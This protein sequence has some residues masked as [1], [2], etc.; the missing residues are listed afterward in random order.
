M[1]N[2]LNVS[3][4]AS[5]P[6]E[7]KMLYKRV[8]PLYTR[9]YGKE[10]GPVALR[11]AKTVA[12]EV[13]RYSASC[14]DPEWAGKCVALASVHP[15]GLDAADAL[16]ERFP[17][18]DYAWLLMAFNRFNILR[19][20]D[21]APPDLKDPGIYRALVSPYI[22]ESNLILLPPEAFV[23]VVDMSQPQFYKGFQA[24]KL[25]EV[26]SHGSLDEIN[27]N[28]AVSMLEYWRPAAIQLLL[29]GCYDRQ[30]DIAAHILYP[31]LF[32]N[33][34][35]LFQSLEGEIN[36]VEE[37]FRE[38]IT[39]II[40]LM[41]RKKIPLAKQT[42][43]ETGE[44]VDFNIRLKTPGSTTIKL[45]SKKEIDPESWSFDPNYVLEQIHDFIAATV[46]ADKVH[47]AEALF[48][49]ICSRD[50]GFIVDKEP[51][52][53]GSQGRQGSLPDYK[54][55]GHIDY[56]AS[57][58]G[59]ARL[60]RTELH[61]KSY[62]AYLD[63]YQCPRTGRGARDS[64]LIADAWG[65]HNYGIVQ[66]LGNFRPEPPNVNRKRNGNG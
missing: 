2:G 60:R 56:E 45:V 5:N 59:A 38:Y 61:V 30:S 6:H 35:N 14:K 20:Q 48:H 58:F 7:R 33:V 46:A 3:A 13:A 28:L 43:R 32:N 25:H 41:A 44:H 23:R 49:L 36:H 50:G 24:Q 27:R 26:T 57:A 65:D 22:S 15:L 18:S 47:D 8:S 53:R 66:A 10:D 39:T 37:K 64:Q 31:Q 62:Q 12:E 55:V 63:Y 51:L 16:M 21:E 34:K 17:K 54:G 52:F 4:L 40:K 29:F 1:T 11:H 42:D 19:N 9:K